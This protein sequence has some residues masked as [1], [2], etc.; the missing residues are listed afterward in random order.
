MFAASKGSKKICELL[1]AHGA[2]VNAQ[3]EYGYSALSQAVK[4]GEQEIC[5]LLIKAMIK[6][7]EKQFNAIQTFL[8]I[9]K[10]RRSEYL[11]LIGRD[12][13]QLIFRELINEMIVQ[14]KIHAE[15]E[16]TKIED[17][18]KALKADLLQYLNTL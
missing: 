2:D 1:I 6:P 18:D 7:T 3:A 9:S 12:A 16:I 4:F 17:G 5:E 13:T 15:S 10:K 8:R 11:K 14:K